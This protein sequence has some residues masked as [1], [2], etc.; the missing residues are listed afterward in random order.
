MLRKVGLVLG[1]QQVAAA[2]VA[3][4]CIFPIG[5]MVGE[6]AGITENLAGILPRMRGCCPLTQN[7]IN[8]VLAAFKGPTA[9]RERAIFITA[10]RTGMRISSILS[11]RV[12]DVAHEG[13]SAEP[14]PRYGGP[15]S[16]ARGRATTWRCMLKRWRLSRKRN[17]THWKIR[18]PWRLFFRGDSAERHSTAFGPGG[19][20]TRRRWRSRAL[21]AGEGSWGCIRPARP[22]RSGSLAALGHDLVRTAYALRHSCVSTTIRCISFDEEDVDRVILSL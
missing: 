18:G 16:R 9:R 17:H 15:P 4:A 14:H 8:R 19:F 13:K 5:R 20:G 7:E 1:E 21:P 3:T 10:L 22:M 2:F 12:E 6:W 11:L